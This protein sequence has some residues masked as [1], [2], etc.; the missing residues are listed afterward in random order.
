MRE[1]GTQILA[2]AS[3]DGMYVVGYDEAVFPGLGGTFD[4]FVQYALEGSDAISLDSGT[5]PPFLGMAE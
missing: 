4:R 1:A 2:W 3:V 5:L